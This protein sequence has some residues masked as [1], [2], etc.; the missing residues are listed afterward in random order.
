MVL[1][2]LRRLGAS[3]VLRA[4][5]TSDPILRLL[6]DDVAVRRDQ[7]RFAGDQQLVQAQS[8]A[9]ETCGAPTLRPA[10]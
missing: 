9:S 3:S 8:A 1:S 6:R 10:Q 2:G 7:P 4:S 5:G